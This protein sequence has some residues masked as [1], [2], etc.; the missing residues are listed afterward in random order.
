MHSASP[1]SLTKRVHPP[2]G[3][4]LA[5]SSRLRRD[6]TR[7]AIQ[8]A[9]DVAATGVKIVAFVRANAGC[10]VEQIR[11]GRGL[12]KKDVALL[13][14]RLKANA[15]A[16]DEGCEAGDEVL[17]PLTCARA[18]RSESRRDWR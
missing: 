8:I 9:K 5:K 13:I 18:L 15:D 4:A 1:A 10:S 6:S 14:V 7:L 12:P 16:Q 11:E 2:S 3:V 17:R